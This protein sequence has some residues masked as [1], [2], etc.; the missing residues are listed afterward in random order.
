MK[1]LRFLPQPVY[2]TVSFCSYLASGPGTNSIT[3]P[4][5]RLFPACHY[6]VNRAYQNVRHLYKGHI[7][8]WHSGCYFR[9]SHRITYIFS[10]VC[11]HSWE[12]VSDFKFV[13]HICQKILLMFGNFERYLSFH[14]S[15][16]Q[17]KIHTDI[18]IYIY[19]CT[20]A[21]SARPIQSQSLPLDK[22]LT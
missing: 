20:K 12:I 9:N 14:A 13:S 19:S 10:V 7:T 17:K 22:S 15:S 6:R 1:R 16:D 5:L 4:V 21:S 3:S 8:G 2:K 18:Y 11:T